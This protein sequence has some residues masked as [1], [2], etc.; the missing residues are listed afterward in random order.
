M[1]YRALGLICS[2]SARTAVAQAAAIR[3]IAFMLRIVE[4]ACTGG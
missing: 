4:G 2:G 3:A 1:V